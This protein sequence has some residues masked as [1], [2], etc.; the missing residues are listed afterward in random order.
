MF[1]KLAPG[2]I[3][4]ALGVTGPATVFAQKAGPCQQIV[5]ACKSAGF[6]ENEY[7]KGYGLQ[8]DCIDPLMNG[9]KQ[10]SN[11]SKP[12]PSVSSQVIAACKQQEPHFGQE[13]A[14]KAK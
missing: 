4:A 9:T 8:M 5:A 14:Q 7:E 11:A 1:A 13:G 6:A 12:L 2:V 3:V 10:P